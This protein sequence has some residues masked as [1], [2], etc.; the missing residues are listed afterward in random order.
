MAQPS[1]TH[2]GGSYASGCGIPN[3]GIA[4]WNLDAVSNKDM[5]VMIDVSDLSV[6]QFPEIMALMRT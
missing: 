3:L 2:G 1:I 4:L 5:E 6:F